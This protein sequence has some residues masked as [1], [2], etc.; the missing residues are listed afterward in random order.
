[1]ISTCAG[2]R[3]LAN[4][5]IFYM[6]SLLPGS[7]KIK[8]LH[9]EGK[10]EKNMI[11]NGV[12]YGYMSEGL[13]IADGYLWSNAFCI[14]HADSQIENTKDTART[15]C[16]SGRGRGDI[17][18]HFPKRLFPRGFQKCHG[19]IMVVVSLH[20]ISTILAKNRKFR[21]LGTPLAIYAASS[22]PNGGG[23]R[24]VDIFKYIWQLDA[25]SAANSAA[26]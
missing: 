6:S 14:V 16:L 22:P 21:Q 17:D 25:N 3:Y 15:D 8:H 10:E 2:L 26:N 13:D 7:W 4:V 12:G 9:A 20:S 18:K 24:G 23:G 5:I 19:L 1:M 11:R